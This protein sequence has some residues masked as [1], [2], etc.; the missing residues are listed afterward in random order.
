MCMAHTKLFFSFFIKLLQIYGTRVCH[1][2]VSAMQLIKNAV[3]FKAAFLAHLSHPC[4]HLMDYPP[5]V[6]V[7]PGRKFG[8]EKAS[9]A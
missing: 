4:L 1:W 8:E 7:I 5:C 6:G 2:L 9:G 3:K